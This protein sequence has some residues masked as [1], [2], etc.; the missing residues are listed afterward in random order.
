MNRVLCWHFIVWYLKLKFHFV[1][2]SS[3]LPSNQNAS[4]L[5]LVFHLSSHPN[6][7][8]KC[9]WLW[10]LCLL[11]HWL[12]YVRKVNE[13]HELCA[14]DC[15]RERVLSAAT[16]QVLAAAEKATRKMMARL[17]FFFLR[18]L[19]RRLFIVSFSSKL[20]RSLVLLQWIMHLQTEFVV[21]NKL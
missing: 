7:W 13:Y 5:S 4:Y 21:S 8:K 20:D 2:S 1:L 3:P 15:M 6:R 19:L 12:L 9:Q 17:L 10:L 16:L 11:V 14:S 18:W